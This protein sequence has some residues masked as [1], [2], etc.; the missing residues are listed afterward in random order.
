MAKPF[1]NER[2]REAIR[3]RADHYNEGLRPHNIKARDQVW[4][5]LDRVKVGYARKLAHLWHGPFRVT[6]MIDDPA[7]RIDI[8]GTKYRIFP[9]VHVSK[10]KPLELAVPEEECVDFDEA[11][12]PE[13]SWV[14]ELDEDEYEVDEIMNIH[15]SRRTRYGRNYREYLVRWKGYDEPTWADEVDLNC[16]ALLR[17]FERSKVSRSRVGV[18][19]SH[20]EE[21]GRDPSH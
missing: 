18:M 13:D 7:A 3:D 11:P 16:G 10:L 1:A 20:E 15:S 8:A 12:L 4:L 17:A 14:R 2:L 6:E 5:Y 9:I 19:Q 21:V